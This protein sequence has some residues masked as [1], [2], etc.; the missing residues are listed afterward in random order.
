MK[1]KSLIEALRQVNENNE[2][3]LLDE[4]GNPTKEIYLSF[5]DLNDVLIYPNVA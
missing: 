5:D 2:V 1:V 4:N 3:R